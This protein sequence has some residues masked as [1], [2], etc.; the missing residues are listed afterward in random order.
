MSQPEAQTVKFYANFR[1][2]KGLNLLQL[3]QHSIGPQTTCGCISWF[4]LKIQKP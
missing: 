2:Q 1:N 3:A 4:P